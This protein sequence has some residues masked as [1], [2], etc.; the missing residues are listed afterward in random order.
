MKIHFKI[1]F[2]DKYYKIYKKIYDKVI[3]QAK[4][5]DLQSRIN[6]SDN[7]VKTT[8][9][10]I[11]EQ[12]NKIRSVANNKP[13]TIKLDDNSIIINQLEI[14]ESFNSYFL[15]I[16]SQLTK[17][18]VVDYDLISD[19]LKRTKIDNV[20]SVYFPPISPLDIINIV[21]SLKNKHS[22][23][24]D[25]I[26]VSLLKQCIGFIAEPLS[27]IF[28]DC[29]QNGI[30][31]D[32]LKVA[33]IIPLF[34][35][36]DKKSMGNYR[37]I[38]LLPAFS[39]ILEKLIYNNICNFLTK[40]N[41]LSENQNGF[42]KNRSTSSTIHN[43]IMKVADALDN[44][45][46]LLGVFCDLS[47]AFD[48]VDH[49]IL[50]MK[51]KFYGFR[52]IPLKLMESY[53]LNRVQVTEIKNI[54]NNCELEYV[55]SEKKI[56]CGVPQG[57]ILGPLLFLIYINDLPFLINNTELFADDTSLTIKDTSVSKLRDKAGEIV[58]E[59]NEWFSNNKLILNSGKS[60]FIQFH[61]MQSKSTID[62]IDHINNSIDNS[63][64]SSVKQ[65]KFLGV[66]LDENLNWSAHCSSIVK[67]LNSAC[68][69][70]R[71]IF[72]LTNVQTAKLVYHSHFESH[73][74]YGIAFW[75]C[76]SAANKVFLVQ[77]R[78]IRYM[79]GLK[80][81]SYIQPHCTEYFKK[82]NILTLYSLFILEAVS[83]VKINQQSQIYNYNIH[84]YNT[85]QKGDFHVQHQTMKLTQNNSMYINIKLYNKLPTDIKNIDRLD[86]FRFQ[87]KTIL[88]RKAY[89]SIDE[90]LNDNTFF[91]STQ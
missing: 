10:I 13:M 90:Y 70:I 65:L 1:F 41:I 29:L 54:H 56:T 16:S 42:R 32:A 46:P 45:E 83:I 23:G 62:R 12:T 5:L 40:N 24:I 66:I 31:P 71:T 39:K 59:L 91:T 73:I 72:Y 84:S 26:P 37:P 44:K 38:S 22:S 36:D 19:N 6:V 7:K 11:N 2:L 28:N 61:S 68:F 30:F 64:L 20:N 52:G 74:R 47:K 34:K 89:Y 69:A 67:K 51:L 48:C 25:E 55:S 9:R 57:S 14:A 53:I 77:K 8:W 17:D 63:L 75:G 85:R 82:H 4:K 3:K 87:I 49:S 15:D 79:C 50:L 80:P 81:K 86:L 21:K 35:K 33:K 76:S 88:V 58:T 60:N 43:L 27:N 18:I 78:A